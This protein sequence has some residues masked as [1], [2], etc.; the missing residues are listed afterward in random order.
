MSNGMYHEKQSLLRC[1]IHAINNLLQAPV[2]D[3]RVMDTACAQLV[4]A[5]PSGGSLS[6][7]LWHPHRAPLGLGNYDVN[8]LMLVLQQQGYDMQW[9][10]KTQRVTAQTLDFDGVVGLL[11]NVVTTG[12]LW[13]RVLEQRHWF[14]IR[15]IDGLCFN[16]DSK[17]PGPMPFAGDDDCRQFL[18]ELL[19]TGECEL[20]VVRRTPP[21]DT[22]T[23]PL[24]S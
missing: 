14:A 21:P 17:L 20:F 15:K 8:V 5:D 12:G 7:W 6:S 19:D 22:S 23:L 4:Q 2:V 24:D 9:V 13:R 10:N 11:C 1:G 18:Q 3:Q 16:L